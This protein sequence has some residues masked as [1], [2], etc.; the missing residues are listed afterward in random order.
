[1]IS[2]RITAPISDDTRPMMLKSPLFT[3]PVPNS[4][5]MN[6]P[7]RNE[8]TI[9]TTILRM[10]P[11]WASRFMMRLATQPMMPPT[12]SQMMKFM[13]RLLKS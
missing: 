8:P 4:G 13:L 6:Q 3:V 11:C 5:A 7:P 12:I 1:M 9:P 2:S 10:M